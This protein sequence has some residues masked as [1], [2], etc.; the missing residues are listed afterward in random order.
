MDVI[1]NIDG[2]IYVMDNDDDKI[3]EKILN[4]QLNPKLIILILK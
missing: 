2:L 3:W 1:K 4:T